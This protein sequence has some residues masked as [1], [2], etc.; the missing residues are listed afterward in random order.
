MGTMMGC[1]TVGKNMMAGKGGELWIFVTFLELLVGS[2]PLSQGVRMEMWK[3]W[4]WGKGLIILVGC[5]INVAS[6]LG[7]KGGKGS[8]AY[9][10][11]KAGVIGKFQVNIL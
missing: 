10:A 5:I 1:R 11:S 4:V 6:L 3:L 2:L 7:A 8:S 9:A